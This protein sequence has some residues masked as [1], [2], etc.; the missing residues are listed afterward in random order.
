MRIALLHPPDGMVPAVPYASLG[1]LNGCL[2]AAGHEVIL[3]D[4]CLEVFLALHARERLEAWHDRAEAVRKDL[5]REEVRTEEQARELHRLQQLLAIPRSLFAEVGDALAVLRDRER[6]VDPDAFNRA[7]DV[8]QSCSRFAYSLSPDGFAG[9]RHMGH[10]VL[11]APSPGPLPDPPIE[12]YG[13]IVERVLATQ[14]DLVG[15]SVP[16]SSSVFY[17]LKL[18][19]AFKE[20]APGIPIIMGG[21]AIDC[22]EYAVTEDPFYFRVLD[23]V[24]VGEGEVQFPRFADALEK[25]EDP[26]SVS[27]LRWVQEDGTVGQTSF[28]L[29]TDLNAIPAPDYSGLPL[30]DYLLPDPVA[31][32][33]TSRGCYYGKCTFCSELFRKSFR[34]RQPD[35]VVEDMVS[36]HRKT[37]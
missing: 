27:N 13:P 28:A 33:Q 3:V 30:G 1:T 2:R 35:L 21:A 16:Y 36:I 10:A 25:G 6:F 26:T 14:P 4:A 37:G 34:I 23:Y 11:A 9:E 19:R 20:R 29:V 24:M 17:G 18:A 32:F 31:T 12:A 5:E 15:I 8:I 22:P 7:H